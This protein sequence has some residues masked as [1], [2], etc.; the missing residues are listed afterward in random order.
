M[1][2]T[3]FAPSDDE[4]PACLHFHAVAVVS[5]A[6]KRSCIF[7]WI[8]L[9]LPR[10]TVPC[11]WARIRAWKQSACDLLKISAGCSYIRIALDGPL[12]ARWRL[13]TGTGTNA[14]LSLPIRS[15]PF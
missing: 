7:R 11:P 10:T 6:R 5:R 1:E 13:S 8:R 15:T 3:R 12:H 2:I 4:V 9:V 14:A